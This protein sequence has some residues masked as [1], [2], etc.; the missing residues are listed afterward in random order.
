MPP[1]NSATRRQQLAD[2]R[3][4]RSRRIKIRI[5]QSCISRGLTYI[6]TPESQR[7]SECEKNNRS[8]EL[9]SPIKE[10]DKHSSVVDKLDEELLELE[11]KKARLRK[12]RRFHLKK[13]REL[14]DREAQNILEL[15]EDEATE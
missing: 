1:N 5:C 12:Q 10:L 3:V 2:K 8:C 14:G 7:C 4:I 13:L 6:V 15:E 11:M 9:T